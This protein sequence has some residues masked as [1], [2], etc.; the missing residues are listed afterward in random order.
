M[1]SRVKADNEWTAEPTI[2]GW[3]YGQTASEPS[4]AAKNG[5]ATVTYGIAGNPGGLGTSRPTMPGSY[6][7]TFAVTESQNY[8]ALSK[9][10]PFTI[11]KA[12]IN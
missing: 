1:E 6:V 9:D 5:T 8:K 12:T 11:A 4:S 3:T 10:V 2:A 7:A